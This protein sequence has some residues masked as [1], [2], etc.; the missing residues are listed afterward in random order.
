[1]Y[2]TPSDPPGNEAQMYEHDYAAG[3][4]TELPTAEQLFSYEK[5]NFLGTE[6]DYTYYVTV[7]RA[8]GLEHG[9]R[10]F[11]F[12][13]SWGY[14]SYQL[15]QAGFRTTAYEIAPTRR[16]YAET[17]LRVN[18][19]GDMDRCVEEAIHAGQYDCF[20]SAHV[21]EHVTTPAKIFDYARK[22]LC[23]GGLF[24]AFT[25]NGSETYR[26]RS[27]DWIRLWG[28]VHPNLIDDIF[29]NASFRNSPRVVGSSPVKNITLP[30]DSQSIIVGPMDGSELVFAARS[31]GADVGW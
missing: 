13:C 26:V 27:Q 23:K 4:T 17:N 19:V 11:D 2:R 12:G 8:L 16:Y 25:P 5:S 3:F 10:V 21:I 30:L 1:M 20:F 6:K 15:N 31:T 14:G 24:V 9:A 18:C 29:L 7:L 22:L 28:Q